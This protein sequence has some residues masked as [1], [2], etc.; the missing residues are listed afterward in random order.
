MG[1]LGYVWHE[2]FQSFAFPLQVPL[3]ILLFRTND[4]PVSTLYT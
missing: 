1:C 4:I 2:K 3:H